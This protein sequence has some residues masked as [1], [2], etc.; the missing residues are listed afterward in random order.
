MSTV[1]VGIICAIIGAIFGNGFLQFYIKRRDE[2]HKVDSEH[3]NLILDDICSL[4]AKLYELISYIDSQNDKLSQIYRDENDLYKEA[5]KRSPSSS[6]F[7]DEIHE[8]YKKDYPSD[9]DLVNI[10]ILR[11]LVDKRY[12]EYSNLMSQAMEK[13][14]EAH[15][16]CAQSVSHVNDVLLPFLGLHEKETRHYKLKNKSLSKQINKLFKEIDRIIKR[17]ENL[18]SCSSIKIPNLYLLEL[19]KIANEAKILISDNL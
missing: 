18:I 4:C 15:E 12:A 13:P 9:T 17:N 6:I 5:F 3:L 7:N 11:D 10:R 8:L 19:Y 2:L 14:K 1:L 16:L